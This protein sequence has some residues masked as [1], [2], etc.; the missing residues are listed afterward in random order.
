[1]TIKNEGGNFIQLVKDTVQWRGVV[2][3]TAVPQKEGTFLTTLYEPLLKDESAL[4]SFISS[5]IHAFIRP[6]IT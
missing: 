4:H 3:T 6:F 5:F 2:S 1:M